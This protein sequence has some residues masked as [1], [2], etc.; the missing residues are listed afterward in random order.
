MRNKLLALAA[1]ACAAALCAC[2]TTQAGADQAPLQFIDMHA[3]Y[4]IENIT[5]DEEIGLLQRVGISRAVFMHNNPAE[6]AAIA[7]K[8]PDF[9]I[10]SLSLT[11]PRPGA[12]ALDENTGAT[13]K[14]LYD[15]HAVC[16]LG[17]IGGGTFGPDSEPL[18][19]IY[20]ALSET[21]APV[22]F[23]IDLNKPEIVAG[24]EKALKDYPKMKF[25]LAHLGW[26]AGPELIGRLLDAH[27][28][29]FTDISIRA[30]APGSLAWRNQGLDLTVLQADETFQPGW[31]KVIDRHPDRFVFATDINSFG[32]RYT[33]EQQLV[34]TARKALAPLPRRT[35]EAIAHGNAERLLGACAKR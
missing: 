8:Y 27:P 31:R 25:V 9:V 3:H 6:L 7:R 21:G 13:F 2:A 22:I 1:A 20:Q 29:L 23:H 34:D 24:V 15:E 19:R 33:I 28:N 32:P 5:P 30:D 26:T 4:M 18:R 10:P 14:K 16:A 11:R 35:Q 12:V 17:E